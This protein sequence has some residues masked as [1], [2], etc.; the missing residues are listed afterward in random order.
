[1]QLLV[2]ICLFFKAHLSGHEHQMT[3]AVVTELG[4][5]VL[6]CVGTQGRKNRSSDTASHDKHLSWARKHRIR[7]IFINYSHEKAM[8]L[9]LLHCC[10]SIEISQ[11]SLTPIHASW[12]RSKTFMS[13]LLKLKTNTL[14]IDK[15]FT[16]WLSQDLLL[17]KHA[18]QSDMRWWILLITSSLLLP[19][20]FMPV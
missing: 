5:R 12:E 7:G 1:M 4:P 2:A 10:I 11:C 6:T 9:P 18:R 3:L 17:G 20:C 8:H 13:T 14:W 19:S 16:C 15:Q